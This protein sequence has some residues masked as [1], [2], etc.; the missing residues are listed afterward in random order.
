MTIKRPANDY[1]PGEEPGNS[2]LNDPK[3][4]KRFESREMNSFNEMTASSQVAICLQAIIRSKKITEIKID[5]KLLEAALFDD[6]EVTL[7][8]SEDGVTITLEKNFGG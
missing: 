3:P 4:R 6:R 7:R 8:T 1:P 2:I 5:K